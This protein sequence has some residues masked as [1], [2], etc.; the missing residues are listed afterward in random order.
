M[1]VVDLASLSVQE[2]VFYVGIGLS[3]GLG[4]IAGLWS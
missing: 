1:M 2:V 3:A 4:F